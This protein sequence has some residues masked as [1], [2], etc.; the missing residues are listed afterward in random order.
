LAQRPPA[1]R[2]FVLFL[3]YWLPV[4][5]YATAVLVVGSQAGLQA[6]LPFLGADKVYHVVE[7]AGL[8]FFLARALRASLRVRWPL[9]AAIM[10][11]V[12]GGLIGVAD[13]VHQRWVPGR[14]S[15]PLDLMADLAG[16]VLAQV[17]YLVTHRD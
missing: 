11:I 4:L 7:Y 10:A 14:E 9:T 2:F 1:R 8:G 5:A 16:L 6:P 3:V 15:S 12:L 17:L 13:E